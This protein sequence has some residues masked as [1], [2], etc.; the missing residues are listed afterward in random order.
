M[1]LGCVLDSLVY[2]NGEYLFAPI[3]EEKQRCRVCGCTESD[4]LGCTIKNG[5][6]PCFWI[7]E[8]LCSVCFSE[9]H[10]GLVIEC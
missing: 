2:V 3:A 8:D 5:G 1:H 4:C 9:M 7:E 6:R 10:Q